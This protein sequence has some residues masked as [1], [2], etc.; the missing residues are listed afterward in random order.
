MSR[1]G[2]SDLLTN[3]HEHYAELLAFLARRLGNVEQAADVAQDTYLR[4]V[5]LPAGEPIQEPRAFLFRIA[6]NLAI[7]RMRREGDSMLCMPMNHRPWRYAIHA[8]HQRLL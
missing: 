3:F 8:L 2:T 1:I 7:D 6:G 4:L 5:N